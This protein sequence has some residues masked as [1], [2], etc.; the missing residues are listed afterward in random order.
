MCNVATGADAILGT[1]FLLKM[2]ARLDFENGKISLKRAEKIGHDHPKGE[3][4]ESLGT[5]A[6]AAPTCFPIKTVAGSKDLV[7]LA[8]RNGTSDSLNQVKN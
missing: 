3:H 5:A 4:C 8:T 7:G 2:D 1:D 6:R